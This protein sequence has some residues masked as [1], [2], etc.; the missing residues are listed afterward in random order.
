MKELPIFLQSILDHAAIAQPK[1]ILT[2]EGLP[3][4]L[5]PA[6][7]GHIQWLKSY[8]EPAAAEHHGTVQDGN[9]WKIG[10]F[11]DMDIVSDAAAFQQSGKI[12]WIDVWN[13]R[14]VIRRSIFNR[15]LVLDYDSEEGLLCCYDLCNMQIIQ[16]TSAHTKSPA[17]ELG[18][19]IRDIYLSLMRSKGWNLFHAA[20]IQANGTTYLFPGSSGSGKTSLVIA[21]VQS[22]ADFIANDR[23]L[24]KLDNDKIRIKPYPMAIAIGLGT[25]QQYPVLKNLILEPSVLQYPRRRYSLQNV[26]NTPMA[27]WSEL[28]DKL[29]LFPHELIKSLGATGKIS[30]GDRVGAVIFPAISRFQVS[31]FQKISRSSA[32]KIFSANVIEG[33][34]DITAPWRPL[35]WNSKYQPRHREIV[36]RLLQLPML[37]FSFHA[38]RSNM[39]EVK[40]YATHL[41]AAMDTFFPGIESGNITSDTSGCKT[42]P[43]D[44]PKQPA[45][46]QSILP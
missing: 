45:D 12:D 2:L 37:K 7:K 21:M 44:N 15:G 25:A 27:K 6:E 9:A 32:E 31:E 18:R 19:L 29:Q 34:D 3:L 14:S 10:C 46:I 22:G 43:N 24:L 20:A 41:G 8:L 23:I 28:P 13:G 5:W 17:H 11:F 40:S 16:V 4:K 38:N 33:N 26:V 42:S 35:P 36:D 1:T 39:N 30:T